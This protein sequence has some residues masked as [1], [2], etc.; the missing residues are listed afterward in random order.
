MN[1]LIAPFTRRSTGRRPFDE[2][3]FELHPMTATVEQSPS[4]EARQRAV[5]AFMVPALLADGAEIARLVER[6]AARVDED[7]RCQ[8]PS[9]LTRSRTELV[10]ALVDGDDAITE[11]SVT[12]SRIAMVGRTSFVE[13]EMRGR[14]THPAFLHDDLMIEPTGRAVT[15]VGVMVLTF[16]GDRVGD[17]RCYH[18]ALELDEQLVQRDEGRLPGR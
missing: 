1:A 7:V 15:S 16:A 13:W 11:I 10:S 14:F 8:S 18:D 2:T 9:L 4:N 5:T 6:I 3:A 17:I 12:L